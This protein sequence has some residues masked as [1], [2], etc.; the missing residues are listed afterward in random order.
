MVKVQQIANNSVNEGAVLADMKNKINVSANVPLSLSVE[1]FSAITSGSIIE[2]ELVKSIMMGETIAEIGAKEVAGKVFDK[3]LDAAV[4]KCG[5]GLVNLGKEF[6]KFAANQ[7]F[8]TDELIGCQYKMEA[9]YHL[10]NAMRSVLK[11]YEKAFIS[12]PTEERAIKFNTALKM[13]YKLQVESLESYKEFVKA[14]NE[15]DLIK[16][17]FQEHAERKV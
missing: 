9:I 1:K 5:L 2:E 16:K 17:D 10:D 8:N 12:N 14:V 11:D 7:L 13:Y 6:G 4:N 15:K 3:T